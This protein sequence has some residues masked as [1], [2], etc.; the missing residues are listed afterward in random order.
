MTSLLVMGAGLIGLRHIA[1]IQASPG[2]PPVGVI[3]A[4][5]DLHTDE[6][7]R[8][9]ASMDD[10]DAAADGVVIATPTTLHAE[11]GLPPPRAAGTC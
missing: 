3:G 7:V 1:A 4:E 9:F 5:F 8:Y 10:V 2:M 6:T 11:N